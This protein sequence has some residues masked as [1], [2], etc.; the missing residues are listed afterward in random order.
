MSETVAD[1]V[2]K[3]LDE[4]GVRRIHG[5]PGDGSGARTDPNVP[6][7]PPHVTMERAKSHATAVPT[8]DP[9]TRG[10]LWHTGT[11]S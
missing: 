10:I 2:P 11:R 1:F 3:R 6:T 7:L 8:G 5:S 9:D 4:W